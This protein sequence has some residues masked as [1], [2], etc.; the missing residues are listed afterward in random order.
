[1]ELNRFS[2]FVLNTATIRQ[3]GQTTW[4]LKAAIWEPKCILVYH[5]KQMKDYALKRYLELHNIEVK[6][7]KWWDKFFKTKKYKKLIEADEYPTF[8]TVDQS[9]IGFKKPVFFD[10]G[11]YMLIDQKI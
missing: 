8:M 10:N 3:S 9:P 5:S 4:L 1:M 6:K 2:K 11:C 7:L